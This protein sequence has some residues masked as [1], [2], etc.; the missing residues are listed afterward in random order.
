MATFKN[1]FSGLLSEKK[2][3]TGIRFCSKETIGLFFHFF[4]I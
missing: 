3:L 4:N 1:A 2:N